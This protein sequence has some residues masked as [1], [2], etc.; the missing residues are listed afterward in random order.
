M[1][2]NELYGYTDVTTL[3]WKN[4]IISKVVKLFCDQLSTTTLGSLSVSSSETTCSNSFDSESDICYPSS[5]P[6]GWK[7]VHIDGPMAPLWLDN[8]NSVLDDSKVLYLPNNERVYLP[9]GLRFLFETD[10]LDNVSPATISRC[11]IV[12]MVSS[13]VHRILILIPTIVQDSQSICWRPY[14]KSW[15]QQLK[16]VS[17][18]NMYLIYAYTFSLY[19]S[20]QRNVNRILKHCL[21]RVLRKEIIF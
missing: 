18:S 19:L 2:L 8:L 15:V 20:S 13:P 12:L 4:G 6:S 1:S 7:W 14:V 16:M 17:L 9:L 21:N 5:A 11:G 10:N 3:E